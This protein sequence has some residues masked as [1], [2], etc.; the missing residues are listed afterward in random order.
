MSNSVLEGILKDKDFN[1]KK[2]LFKIV[3][4]YSLTLDELLLLIFFLNQDKP[5]LNPKIISDV[6]FMNE[7][8]IL[9]AFTSLTSKGLISMKI[10]KQNDG[11]VNETIDLSNLFKAMVSDINIT[12]KKDAENNL[13][14]TFEKE[15]GRPLSP[16]EYEIINAWVKSGITE[17]IIIGALKEATYNGVSNLRYIDKI[18]Y[19]WGKKGFKTM[20]DV[21]EHLKKKDE[22]DDNKVLFDYNWLDDEE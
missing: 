9:E 7:K 19:E 21:N 5:V 10:S 1:F 15:F 4:D 17:E 11:K 18:I 14:A 13:F 3:K 8:N 2:L 6:T 12:S 22:K 20:N 16:M